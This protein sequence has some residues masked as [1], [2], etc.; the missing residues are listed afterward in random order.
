[1]R[2]LDSR[3]RTTTATPQRTITPPAAPPTTGSAGL[4]VLEDEDSAVIEV[5]LVEGA[6]VEV[7]PADGVVSLLFCGLDEV[8]EHDERIATGSHDEGMGAPR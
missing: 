7:T 1:M 4:G 8:V 5:I 2:L 3:R 6:S